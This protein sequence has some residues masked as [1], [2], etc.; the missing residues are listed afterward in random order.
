MIKTYYI[1]KITNNVSGKSYIGQTTRDDPSVRWTEHKKPSRGKVSALSSAIKKYGSDSFSFELIDIAETVESLNAKEIFYISFFNTLSP[2]GYNLTVGGLNG[3]RSEET[4]LKM[5]SLARKA[6]SE[7]TRK[8]ISDKA[9]ARAATPE[10][11]EQQRLMVELAKKVPYTEERLDKIRE[12][13]T[14]RKL[15]PEA[16]A[17]I[18]EA[19]KRRKHSKPETN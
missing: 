15:S 14:G 4:K 11:K 10:W 5:K 12:K 9:K 16:R 13:S 17:K 18:G 3:L 1:Y 7:E 19:N 8:K 6:M 2:S